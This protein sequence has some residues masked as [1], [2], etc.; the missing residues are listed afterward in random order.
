MHQFFESLASYQWHVY[1]SKS[2]ACPSP[3]PFDLQAQFP[4]VDQFRNVSDHHSSYPHDVC[5]YC[6]YFNLDVH[7]R[8][9]YDVFDEPRAVK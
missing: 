5:S 4:Y 6:Q 2:F 7:L 3:L 1:A 9:Y 8:L